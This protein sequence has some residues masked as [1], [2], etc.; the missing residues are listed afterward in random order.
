MDSC[1]RVP[2]SRIARSRIGDW[3]RSGRMD[4]QGSYCLKRFGEG[5]RIGLV[6]VLVFCRATKGQW[7]MKMLDGEWW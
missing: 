3:K 7:Q 2:A 1:E 6:M 5:T 4:K